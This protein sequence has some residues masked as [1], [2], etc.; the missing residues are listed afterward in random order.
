MGLCGQNP[1][2][3]R[4][5]PKLHQISLSVWA[6]AY[7]KGVHLFRYFLS[8]MVTS[9]LLVAV[10]RLNILF[11]ISKGVH[12]YKY[13]YFSPDNAYTKLF[14]TCCSCISIHLSFFFFFLATQAYMQLDLYAHTTVYAL[15]L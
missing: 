6:Q 1:N 11:L 5:P 15:S 3:P 13:M 14:A 12:P 7:I 8:L 10:Y 2:F 9:I 4:E